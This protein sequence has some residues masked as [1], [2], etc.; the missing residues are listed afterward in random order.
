[1]EELGTDIALG[2]LRDDDEVWGAL[3]DR[4]ISRE[5]AKGTVEQAQKISSRIARQELGEKG[6]AELERLG[7]QSQSIR[8]LI[9]KHG[10]NRMNGT[11][12]VGWND[13]LNLA[14]QFAAR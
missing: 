10:I 1:V 12:K 6:F 3:R 7:N 2:E 14:R 5:A 4:G 9:V 11:A 13:V 8:A